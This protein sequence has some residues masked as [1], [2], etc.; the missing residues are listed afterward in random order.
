ME[1]T[2]FILKKTP[3]RES[4]W[5]LTLFCAVHGKINALWR[6]SSKNSPSV[7]LF[8]LYRLVL[9]EG[10]LGGSFSN[11]KHYP[12]DEL[13]FVQDI[14]QV[15]FINLHGDPIW[16]AYYM[17]ELL[18]YLFPKNMP[19]AS[20]FNAYQGTLLVL[21]SSE[22]ILPETQFALRIF[23]MRLLDF[24][25]ILPDFSLI[26]AHKA[27]KA[28]YLSAEQGVVADIA[29][30]KDAQTGIS[31][32]YLTLPADFFTAFQCFEDFAQDAYQPHLKMLKKINSF[33]IKHLLAG[34]ELKSKQMYQKLKQK[35]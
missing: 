1:V 34:R 6:N 14:E 26:K 3:F 11:G 28:Y 22:I 12:A 5:I 24:I 31:S 25:G 32:A 33:L 10:S 9:K 17:N 23:E 27:A 30:L 4:G 19:D 18:L 13:F 16:I 15:K 8:N 35:I 2:A 29:L 21:Q 7:E 20:L